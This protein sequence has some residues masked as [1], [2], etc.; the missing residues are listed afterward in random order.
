MMKI[1][2][3]GLE[4]KDLELQL[5]CHVIRKFRSEIRLL[6]NQVRVY[7]VYEEQS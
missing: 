1:G 6:E 2:T 5:P 4:N 3:Q 7:M